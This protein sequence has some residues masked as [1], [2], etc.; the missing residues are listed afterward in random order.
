MKK[1]NCFF[2]IHREISKKFVY[3]HLVLD[4]YPV[5]NGHLLIV[6]N[7]HESNFLNCVQAEYT[8]LYDVFELI[9]EKF[10]KEDGQQVDI[11][12][13]INIGKNAGQTIPHVHIHVIPRRAGDVENPE[14]GVRG[15]IPSKQFYF[16]E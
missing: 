4:Q 14:G 6:L 3:W 5:S 1:N 11:N 2:C 7:R 13:G 12:I 9:K 8:E 16:E 10:L 15:V